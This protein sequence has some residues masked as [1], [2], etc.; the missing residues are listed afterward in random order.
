MKRVGLILMSL[1]LM[2][3]LTGCGKKDEGKVLE[4]T[5]KTNGANT[6]YA[7]NF[8]KDDNLSSATATLSYTATEEELKKTSLSDARKSLEEGFAEVLEEGTYKVTDNGKDTVSI[9]IEFNDEKV[10]EL[11]Q[12]EEVKLENIQESLE[13]NEFICSVK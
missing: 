3:C 12:N 7:F 4:C 2:V 10:K 11:I 1:S 5:G 13:K 9:T 6:T 8:T